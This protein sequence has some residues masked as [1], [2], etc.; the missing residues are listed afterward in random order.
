MPVTD[1]FV[2]PKPGDIEPPEAWEGYAMGPQ[3]RRYIRSA[4]CRDGAIVANTREFDDPP[5]NR[6]W[7]EE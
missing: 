1:P 5:D 3:S 2:A 6:T 4:A 7:E